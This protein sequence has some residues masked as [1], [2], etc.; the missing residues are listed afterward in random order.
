VVGEAGLVWPGIAIP[1]PASLDTPAWSVPVAR[2][3]FALTTLHVACLLPRL[4][5]G[6]G[7]LV[8]AIFLVVLLGFPLV[9]LFWNTPAI[10]LLPSAVLLL[11]GYVLMHIRQ[12]RRLQ[13]PAAGPAVSDTLPLPRSAPPVPGPVVR[14][15]RAPIIGKILGHY[16]VERLLG[17]GAMGA[18]YLGREVGSERAVAIKTMALAQEFEASGLAEVKARFFREVESAGRLRHPNIVVMYEAGEEGDLAYIAMEYLHGRDLAAFTKPDN[19]LPL[20]SVLSILARVAEA[21]ACAH[22]NSVVHR[23][24]KPAN[25][26]YEPVTDLVKVMD[27]GVARLTDASKTKTGMVLGS[28]SYMS[29]EQLLGR[30][31]DGRSDLFSLGVMLYQLAC[32]RLPFVAESMGRLMYKITN[33]PAPDVRSV[34]PQVPDDVVTVI[35][36]AMSKSAEQ[37]YQTADEMARDLR[38]CLDRLRQTAVDGEAGKQ[39]K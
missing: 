7:T 17:K 18:V 26:I 9:R 28:P 14:A 39:G 27:F 23:D 31:V 4:S 29:P 24:V 12:L 30:K 22:R 34:N 21:L 36:R 10:Q 15:E 33:E 16:R 13:R 25:V 32:G 38:A 20:P 5:A 2:A 19:L 11:A 3:A 1:L 8:S 37:R 6:V 35:E